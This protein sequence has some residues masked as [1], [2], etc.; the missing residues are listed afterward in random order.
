[1]KKSATSHKVDVIGFVIK[2]VNKINHD[3][4]S[5]IFIDIFDPFTLKVVSTFMLPGES[6]YVANL[7]LSLGKV[8]LL[9]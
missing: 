8:D 2:F 7:L 9:R 5:L 1:M 4:I 6:L 3:S